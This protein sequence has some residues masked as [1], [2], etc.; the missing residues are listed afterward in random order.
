[1]GR[2]LSFLAVAPAGLRVAFPAGSME[3]K[4]AHLTELP[5]A[6]AAPAGTFFDYA[7]LHLVATATR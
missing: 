1:M 2:A 3:G 4:L 7:C 5:L 6:A